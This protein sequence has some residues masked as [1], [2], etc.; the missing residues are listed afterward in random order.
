MNTWQLYLLNWQGVS[1][2]WA[3]PI[4]LVY[5]ELLVWAFP[6]PQKLNLTYCMK[7]SLLLAFCFLLVYVVDQTQICTSS[8]LPL[9]LFHDI[10]FNI[11]RREPKLEG[12]PDLKG[13][14]SDPSS[15]HVTAIPNRESPV[16]SQKGWHFNP[17]E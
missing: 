9:G 12:G 4:S 7:S 3:I 6:P 1:P 15:Y 8:I 13:G 14:T 5:T 16:A 2:M 17:A 10:K 11:E